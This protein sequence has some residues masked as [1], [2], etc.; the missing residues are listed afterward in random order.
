[1]P[2]AEIESAYGRTKKK[3]KPYSHSDRHY[4]V[5]DAMHTMLRAREIVHNKPLLKEVRKHAAK[6]A[7][8]TAEVAKHAAALAKSG[9]ISPKAMKKLGA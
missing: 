7:H 2:H 3:E 5:R 4:E 1:M 8:E 9:H 6:H